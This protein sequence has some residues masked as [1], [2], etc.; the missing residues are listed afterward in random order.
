M[1]YFPDV[2]VVNFEHAGHWLHHDQTLSFLHTLKA[3]L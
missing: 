1:A 3:F 2:R